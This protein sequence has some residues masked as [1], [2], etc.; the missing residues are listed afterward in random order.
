M[1]WE[2]DLFLQIQSAAPFHFKCELDLLQKIGLYSNY[3]EL[4][5]RTQN[6]DSD[7]LMYFTPFHLQI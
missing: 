5:K 6:V 2:L 4:Y 3:W 1:V 7:A